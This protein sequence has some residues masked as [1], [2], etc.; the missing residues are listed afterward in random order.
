M[1]QKPIISHFQHKQWR[2]HPQT[3]LYPQ[4]YC[5]K[6]LESKS[7]SKQF[8]S[9]TS[10]SAMRPLKPS[11]RSS[12]TI[13]NTI[14]RRSSSVA[15]AQNPSVSNNIKKSTNILTQAKNLSDVLSAV[16]GSANVASLATIV[17]RARI[18][19]KHLHNN[20]KNLLSHWQLTWLAEVKR[21]PAVIP[22]RTAV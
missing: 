5:R 19:L 21:P 4:L 11:S 15:F 12:G 18:A 10:S 13:R 8:S 17:K 22:T 7:K 6:A 3:K 1:Q 20:S 16:C 9:V 2:R 14:L